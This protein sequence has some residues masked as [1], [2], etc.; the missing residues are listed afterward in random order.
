MLYPRPE[1]PAL[2]Q[3]LRLQEAKDRTVA[4]GQPPHSPSSLWCKSQA[5]PPPVLGRRGG[6]REVL[7]SADQRQGTGHGRLRRAS[8]FSSASSLPSPKE[9]P[10]PVG[11]SKGCQGVG[12]RDQE[13]QRGYKEQPE[14]R[15]L[16]REEFK[17]PREGQS[18]QISVQILEKGQF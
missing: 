12:V 9:S 16:I 5:I 13:Q 7:S 18:Y 4:R 17:E 8:S 2:T 15:Q 1:R 11:L 6:G 10:L 3:A 14:T